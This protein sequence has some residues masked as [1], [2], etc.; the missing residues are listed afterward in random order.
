MRA[1]ADTIDSGSGRGLGSRGAKL[2]RLRIE[3]GSVSDVGLVRETNEDAIGVLTLDSDSVQPGVIRAAIAVADGMGGHSFGEVASRIAVESVLKSLRPGVSPEASIDVVVGQAVS[4]AN[5]DV[6]AATMRLES[7]SDAMGTT[8]TVAAVLDDAVTVGHVGDTR[9]YLLRGR[10]IDQLTKDHTWVADQVREGQLRPEEARYHRDRHYL[11]RSLG[12]ADIVEVDIISCE[13]LRD[14]DVLVL[15]SDGLTGHI[16]DH[17]ILASVHA[18]DTPQRAAEAMVSLAK[19]RGGTDNVS[20]VIAEFGRCQRSLALATRAL[21]VTVAL[22]RRRR[23]GLVAAA[24]AGLIVA[25]ATPIALIAPRDRL[26]RPLMNRRV[27]PV[28]PAKEPSRQSTVSSGP[29]SQAA[30]PSM[31]RVPSTAI[32]ADPLTQP[33]VQK[34]LPSVPHAAARDSVRRDIPVMPRETP[35]RHL[36]LGTGQAPVGDDGYRP[37]SDRPKSEIVLTPSAPR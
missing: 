27:E 20:V 1:N 15:C 30:A 35:K 32:P 31:K 7:G 36:S 10:I 37:E 5:R 12:A 2:G 21:D 33:T 3:I 14:G 23:W 34:A 9:V 29:T 22:P 4:Q 8:V 17:E 16:T 19:Q 26:S 18:T 25:I 11:T 6:R 24:V 28:R 13:A